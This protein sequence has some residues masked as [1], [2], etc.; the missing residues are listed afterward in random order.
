MSTLATAALA[1]SSMCAGE[2][3]SSPWPKLKEP[4]FHVDANFDKL[5]DMREPVMA[6]LDRIDD[7]LKLRAGHDVL[8][9]LRHQARCLIELPIAAP[10]QQALSGLE[11]LLM[12]SRDWERI[13]TVDV[14]LETQLDPLRPLVSRW[15]KLELES[16]NAS[17]DRVSVGCLMY[18]CSAQRLVAL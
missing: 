17:L 9:Y 2:T 10:V 4:N 16:W 5:C 13:A 3:A 14:S 12:K 8:K 7:V 18:E 6:L 1:G 15:R 11:S